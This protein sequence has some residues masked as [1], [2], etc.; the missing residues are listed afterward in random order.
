MKTVHELYLEHAEVSAEI[1]RNAGKTGLEEGGKQMQRLSKLIEI[2]REILKLM[3][4][5]NN[6]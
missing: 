5:G 4:G 1:Q 6:A 3:P 2:S